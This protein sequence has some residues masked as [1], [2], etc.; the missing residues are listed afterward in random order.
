LLLGKVGTNH[1][2]Y[3]PVAQGYVQTV[4]RGNKTLSLVVVP[5]INY[6]DASQTA[7]GIFLHQP[8]DATKLSMA[9]VGGTNAQDPSFLIYGPNGDV[10]KMLFSQSRRYLGWQLVTA[11]GA[12]GVLTQTWESFKQWLA[13]DA[14]AQDLP[15][16]LDLL[17]G[18]ACGDALLGTHSPWSVSGCLHCVGLYI[19]ACVPTNPT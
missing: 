6:Y 18:I 7:G 10:L 14:G 2:L 8:G 11:A 9:V 16:W 13:S 3:A 1:S 19:S 17:C 15:W 4:A 12:G 5:L